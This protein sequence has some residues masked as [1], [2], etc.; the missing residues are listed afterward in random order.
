MA[1]RTY[2]PFITV[3]LNLQEKVKVQTFASSVN[4][5]SF[6]PHEFSLKLVC[7]CSD[8][9]VHVLA[10]KPD[11]RA[12]FQSVYFVLVC[13]CGIVMPRGIDGSEL[14]F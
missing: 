10:H 11:V 13:V 9:N 4:S 7:A 8:G 3:R 2:P 14:A 5:L 1:T 6:A 12:P